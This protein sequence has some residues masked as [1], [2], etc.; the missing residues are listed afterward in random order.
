MTSCFILSSFSLSPS[1]T[2]P[3]NGFGLKKKKQRMKE[4]CHT[5][6]CCPFMRILREGISNFRSVD[7]DEGNLIIKRRDKREYTEE[8]YRERKKKR[9]GGGPVDRYNSDLHTAKGYLLCPK[10]VTIIK[11]AKW[12]LLLRLILFLSVFTG[13]GRWHQNV[14]ILL[15]EG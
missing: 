15:C 11:S 2:P 8:N 4:R 12:E 9:G 5:L 3:M 13:F 7:C 10:H 6:M 1:L 14:T